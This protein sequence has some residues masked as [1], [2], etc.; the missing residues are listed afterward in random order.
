MS[1]SERW[2]WHVGW[3]KRRRNGGS[4]TLDPPYMY[5]MFGML[6][7]RS[8]RH[9]GNTALPTTGANT[10]GWNKRSGSTKTDTPTARISAINA[11]EH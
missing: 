2:E 11:S 7:R 3:N 5:G 8:P 6:S 4:A 1:A 9:H 10:V